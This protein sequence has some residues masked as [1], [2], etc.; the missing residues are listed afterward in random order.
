MFPLF[1]RILL[2]G[3]VSLAQ[4]LYMTASHFFQ[5]LAKKRESTVPKLDVYQVKV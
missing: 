3:R 1:L 2:T 4:K 5:R